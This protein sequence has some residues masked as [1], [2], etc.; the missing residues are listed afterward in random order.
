MNTLL[1]SL[2]G[3]KTA[4]PF[5]FDESNMGFDQG[6]WVEVKN[7]MS[8]QIENLSPQTTMSKSLNDS[9]LGDLNG[10]NNQ[11]STDGNTTSFN[12]RT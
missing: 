7:P 3:F 1:H 6:K 12:K 11:N 10:D 8:T 4:V 9:K 5:T 2:R